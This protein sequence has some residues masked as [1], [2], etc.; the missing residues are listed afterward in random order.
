LGNSAF[1]FPRSPAPAGFEVSGFYKTSR[2]FK[3]REGKNGGWGIPVLQL[4]LSELFY[5]MVTLN[6]YLP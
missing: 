2:L 4:A 1:L 5:F 3:K 6:I